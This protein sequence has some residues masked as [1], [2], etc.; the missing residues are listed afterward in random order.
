[1]QA[2][3]LDLRQRVLDACQSGQSERDVAQRFALSLSSVQRYKRAHRATGSPAPQPWPGRAPKI[4]KEHKDQL[5]ALVASRTDWTL[6]SL[7]AAWK[8]AN[9]TTVARDVMGRTLARFGITHKKRVASLP[10]ATRPSGRRSE[11]PS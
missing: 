10:S 2:Y 6:V 7:C 3:S 4:K 1:M 5:H 11:K 9:G 8:E